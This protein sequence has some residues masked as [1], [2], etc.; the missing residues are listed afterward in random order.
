MA[1]QARL[2]RVLESGEFMK[3]SSSDI[4]ITDIRVVAATNVDLETAVRGG[5]F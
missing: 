5:K 3:V 1:T 2:L 4:S